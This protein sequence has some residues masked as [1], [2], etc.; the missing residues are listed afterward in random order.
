MAER[1][2]KPLSLLQ[3]VRA[4]ELASKDD[5]ITGLVARFTAGVP[6]PPA[7]T[8]AL[9][10]A[11]AQELHNAIEEF[12]KAKIAKF[13]PEK[14]KV[15][16]YTESF[17][18]QLHYYL[19]TAFDK[20]YMQPTGSLGLVGLSTTV[21]FFKLLLDKLGIK[22]HAETRNEYKSV[23][24]MATETKWPEKQKQNMIDLMANLNDQFVEVIARARTRLLPDEENLEQR[25]QKVK[26][27]MSLGSLSAEEAHQ[28]GLID[29]RTYRHNVS[30]LVGRNP[31]KALPHYLRVREAERM[32]EIKNKPKVTVG[33][34]YLLGNII[35][36]GGQY[37]AQKVT[38]AILDAAMDPHVDS[39]LLRID[40]GGGDVVA[41][42]TIWEA[43]RRVQILQRKPVIVSFANKSA[44]GGYYVS[45]FCDA[46]IANPATITGSIGVAAVRPIITQKFL[47]TLN[48]SIDDIHLGPGTKI[49]SPFYEM[50]KDELKRYKKRIDEMYHDFL[51]RVSK[52]RRI[53][54]AELD[55][56]AGGRVYTGE[57][58]KAIN[59]VDKLGGLTDAID[60]AAQHAFTRREHLMQAIKGIM[61]APVKPVVVKLEELGQHHEEIREHELHSRPHAPSKLDEI[62]TKIENEIENE[63]ENE[64]KKDESKNHVIG[65]L[66][67]PEDYEI[68]VKVFPKRKSFFEM[69]SEAQ[70]MEDY[71]GNPNLLTSLPPYFLSI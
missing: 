20:I 3:I 29:G 28:H 32:K 4:L 33:L 30:A 66:P 25:I 46:I 45:T 10:L 6:G 1:G 58:A 40:S 48:L 60:I 59:L 63:S 18:N 43:V 42:D 24:S 7:S 54:M 71:S 14:V 65:L 5:R 13:G 70:F 26:E 15:V 41:S 44:S 38:K 61:M 12:K 22:I 49:N 27:L 55:E 51:I 31:A 52:G 47:D 34:V 21:P 35:R 19:A 69:L 67:V 8:H 53:P 68:I 16:A 2:A 23:A 62:K 64:N 39:I 11:Q 50:T 56:I 17:D 36:T 57:Q 9:G 37:N